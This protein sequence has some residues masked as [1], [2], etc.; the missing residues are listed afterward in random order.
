MA[1][2]KTRRK[3]G[4]NAGK[5]NTR[6]PARG[7]RRKSYSRKTASGRKRATASRASTRSR[8]Q[9]V[10]LVIEQAPVATPMQSAQEMLTPTQ[11][12]AAR[13]RRF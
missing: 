3:S 7:V 13:V 4:G 12:Q 1:Y 5:R 11:T 8:G 10:R 2:K 6:V 9:T